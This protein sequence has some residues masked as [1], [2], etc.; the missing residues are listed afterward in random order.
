MVNKN[1]S[2]SVKELRNLKGF[3]QEQLAKQSGLSLRTIQRVEKGVTNPSGETLKRIS[4]TFDIS[5]EQ[6]LIYTN[7]KE[8]FITT[9]NA[10]NEYLHIFNNKLIISNT[11]D[12]N[13][14]V[15]DYGNS[16]SN[17]LKISIVFL[18]FTSFFVFLG[19]MFFSSHSELAFFSGAFALFFLSMGIYI[20]L[21]TSSIPSIDINLIKNISI[22]SSV[23]GDAIVIYH[24]DMGIIKKRNVVI[25]KDKIEFIKNTF[26]EENHYL[27]NIVDFKI[28]KKRIR[29]E[30]IVL[31]FIM[32]IVFYKTNIFENSILK[33]NAILMLLLSIVMIFLIIKGIIESI[34][35]KKT[36]N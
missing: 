14:I 12:Y 33:V 20:M 15:I 10:K 35:W 21:F 16:V 34:T 29:L 26:L 3:S 11:K 8:A 30:T 22:Q 13:N 25:E 24:F 28:T 5:C 27:S 31:L 2:E 7:S 36:K 23:L 32:V 9:I 19:S 1:L 18:V 17:T 4:N 6:L